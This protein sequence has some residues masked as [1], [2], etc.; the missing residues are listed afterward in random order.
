MISY[1]RNTFQELIFSKDPE[2]IDKGM[3][4][5]R[6]TQPRTIEDVF[7]EIGW[8]VMDDNSL[9]DR[10]SEHTYLTLYLL[11]VMHDFGVEWVIELEELEVFLEGLTQIPDIFMNL[12]NLSWLD[13]SSNQLTQ[14]PKSI[15]N[16]RNLTHLNLSDNPLEHFPNNLVCLTTDNELWEIFQTEI[17]NMKTLKN[18][19]L[20]DG[21]T[22]TTLPESF[23]N[24]IDLTS[25]AF[26]ETKMGTIPDS[27]TTLTNLTELIFD[28]C[29]L[30]SLSD[31]IGNLTNLKN[32]L[33]DY[34]RL[35]NLPESIGKLTNLT[36]L[37]LSG[38]P[39]SESEQASIQTLLPNC[40]VCFT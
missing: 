18:L 10:M 12:T 21:H 34:N 20:Y 39:I 14:I 15:E 30:T 38:N 23:E 28:S 2:R 5:L 29:Q 31:S 8:A 25:L 37:G 3:E 35:T 7:V 6:S 4:L 17:C 9:S 33:L 36:Y 13:L 1:S 32:L 22:L 24:L 27:V 16:L 26:I 11:G 40:D 19:A